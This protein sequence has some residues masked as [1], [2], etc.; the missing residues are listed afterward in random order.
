MPPPAPAPVQ[1]Q[2]EQPTLPPHNAGAKQVPISL[3]PPVSPPPAPLQRQR[4]QPPVSPLTVESRTVPVRSQVNESPRPSLDRRNSYSDNIK[5]RLL[6][7]AKTPTFGELQ[8]KYSNSRHSP[9]PMSDK[10]YQKEARQTV[11][12]ELSG[13]GN[14]FQA[15]RISGRRRPSQSPSMRLL[16]ML[17]VHEDSDGKFQYFSICS[18]TLTIEL[19]PELSASSQEYTGDR[20]RF[21][22]PRRGAG[23][24]NYQRSLSSQL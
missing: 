17:H 9:S 7:K 24:G 2:R 3:P 11:V 22:P 12:G 6:T 21:M 19:S 5:T 4:E 10:D 16:G 1:R 20:G 14:S 13:L 18:N 8:Y 23:P 15:S